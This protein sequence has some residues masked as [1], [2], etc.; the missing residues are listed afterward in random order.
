M[1]PS[2][3]KL[4]NIEKKTKLKFE[5]SLKKYAAHSYPSGKTLRYTDVNDKCEPITRSL[6]SVGTSGKNE[7]LLYDVA[8]E[9]YVF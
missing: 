5:K 8:C 1:G 2:E 6:L 7:L 3:K 9:N 4:K